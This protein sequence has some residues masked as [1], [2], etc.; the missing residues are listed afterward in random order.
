MIKAATTSST[1]SYYKH[2]YT[3]AIWVIMIIHGHWLK[4]TYIYTTR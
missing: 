3:V 4:H 1:T 2:N